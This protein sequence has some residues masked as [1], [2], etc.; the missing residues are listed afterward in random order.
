MKAN[1]TPFRPLDS[2]I[3]DEK[4]EH[5]AREKGVDTLHRQM[6][7][8]EQGSPA[9]LPEAPAAADATLQPNVATT[10]RSRMKPLNVELPDYAWTELKIRASAPANECPARDLFRAGQGRHHH[11]RCG[12]DRR[13]AA[14][15]WKRC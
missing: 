6:P 13:W 14:R 5:L 2:D 1:R 4:I 10:P 12:H 8:D 15:A 11:Y 3:A 9:P 7:R